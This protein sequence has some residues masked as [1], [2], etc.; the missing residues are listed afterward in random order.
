MNSKNYIN[1]KIINT[2]FN[3][4]TPKGKETMQT[5]KSCIEQA[6]ANISERVQRE[7]PVNGQ[8]A[9]IVEKFNNPETNTFAKDFSIEVV[10][11][12]GKELK[13]TR[14]VKIVTEHPHLDKV[15]SSSIFIGSTD[16]VKDFF[17]NPK[18]YTNWIKQIITEDSEKLS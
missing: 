7:M 4:V 8:F 13:D 10:P 18:K 3:G 12:I 1:E 2:N 16:E 17:K 15:A 14:F 5:F 6:L 9:K 11:G